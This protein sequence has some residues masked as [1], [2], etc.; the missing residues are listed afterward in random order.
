MQVEALKSFLELNL[1]N[2]QRMKLMDVITKYQEQQ[3]NLI[4]RM[5]GEGRGLIRDLR[6][7]EFNEEAARLA[8]RKAS[9]FREDAFILKLKMM[10]DIK[11]LLTEEQQK[12]LQ[13]RKL[14]R[15][16]KM[17]ERLESILELRGE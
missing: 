16:D 7:E 8:Y 12:M 2:D 11:S 6:S 14:Q 5:R 1:T 13:E 9:S 4:E 3:R 10:H 17:M 15:R